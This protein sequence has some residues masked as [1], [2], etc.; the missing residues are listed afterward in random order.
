MKLM[1]NPEIANLDIFTGLSPADLKWVAPLVEVCS[2]APAEVV[3]EQGQMAAYLFV[4]LKGKVL[5]HFKPYDGP[6][7][8]VAHIEAGGVF[9]WSAVLGRA[10]YTSGAAAAEA[11]EA[12]R[13][14]GDKLRSL[15]EQHPEIGLVVLDQLASVIAERLRSTHGQILTMLTEGMALSAEWRQRLLKHD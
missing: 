10:T 14:R 12:I 15:C 11:S 2:F 3:F 1:S 7:L 6:A 5:V 8:T 13:L 4:L 9:G